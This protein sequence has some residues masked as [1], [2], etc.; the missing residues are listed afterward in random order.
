M[1]KIIFTLI[2][3]V[4]LFCGCNSS[5]VIYDTKRTAIVENIE[6]NT[7]NRNGKYIVK[8]LSFNPKLKRYK[9]YTDSLYNKEQ[10]I[11]IKGTK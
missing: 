2:F 11:V 10:I 3:T 9:I 1:R 8:A 4:F 5:K 6:Y 7:T